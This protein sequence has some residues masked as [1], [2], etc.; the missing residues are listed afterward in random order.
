V[1]IYNS[2]KDITQC[3]ELLFSDFD[4]LSKCESINKMWLSYFVI[5]IALGVL[6]ETYCEHKNKIKI[7]SCDISGHLNND[8]SKKISN[9]ETI[10]VPK[11][12]LLVMPLHVNGNHWVIMFADF[13]NHK[14][15]FLEMYGQKCIFKYFPAIINKLIVITAEFM[16][17][18]M[19]S[20]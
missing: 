17:C 1:G 9:L 16:C 12:S 7:L 10:V 6:R 13:G 18:T 20:V 2:V 14:F 8:H 19:Q 5:D 4:T 15:Y 3:H 11:D